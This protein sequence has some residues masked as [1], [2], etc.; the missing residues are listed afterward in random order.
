MPP[1]PPPPLLTFGDIA[2]SLLT[3][4]SH[5]AK[6]V[7]VVCDVYRTPSIKDAERKRHGSEEVTFCITGPNQY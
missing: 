7:H 4:L 2:R 5:I 3:Q 1:P 6:Q